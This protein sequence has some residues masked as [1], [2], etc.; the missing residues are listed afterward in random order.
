MRVDVCDRGGSEEAL[1][2]PTV[3]SQFPLF[4]RPVE[5]HAQNVLGHIVSLGVGAGGVTVG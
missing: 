1:E 5:P 3:E 2:S 4:C